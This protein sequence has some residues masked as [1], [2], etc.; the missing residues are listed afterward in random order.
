MPPRAP[1]VPPISDSYA[2]LFQQLG[3]DGKS[4]AEV[5]KLA[6]DIRW[7]GEQRKAEERRDVDAAADR[8]ERRARWWA[9]FH[10]VLAA[11]IGLAGAIF[12]PHFVRWLG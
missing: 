11:T 5:R 9:L 10:V 12:G 4:P 3:I 8:K 1:D 7:I 2:E 6:D